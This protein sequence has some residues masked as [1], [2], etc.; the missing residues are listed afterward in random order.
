M[1]ERFTEKARRV[2]FFAHYEASQFSSP[3]IETEH[4]LLGILHE[5]RQL[6]L[7]FLGASLPLESIRREIEAHTTVREKTSTTADLPLSNESKRVLA[8]AAEEAEQLGHGHI[9]TKHFFLGLLREEKSFAAE[10]LLARGVR[11]ATVREQLRSVSPPSETSTPQSRREPDVLA[12]FSRNLNE[13]ALDG[14][15]DPLIGR[16]S[17]LDQILQVLSRRANHNAVLLG[18][19][20]VGKKTIVAG[21]AQRVVDG[22]VPEAFVDHL[23][24]ELNL[25]YLTASERHNVS[26]PRI[27]QILAQAHAIFV[28]DELHAPHPG[29][30]TLLDL[31]KP[32]VVT[33]QIRCISL[34]TPSAYDESL[35]RHPWLQSCFQ[36]ISVQ[37]A[38]EQETL[39]V[40]RGTIDRFGKFH[41]A[42]YSDDALACAVHYASKLVPGHLP[43][44]AISLI[45]EAGA[46]INIKPVPEEIRR[47]QQT[48]R[49][50]VR[51]TREAIVA[52]EF[53]KARFYS[54][55]ERKEREKLQ[56]EVQKYGLNTTDQKT[57]NRAQIEATVARMTGLSLATVQRLGPPTLDTPTS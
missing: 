29:N 49:S 8:Y 53:A 1:F 55:E 47:L 18:P 45:D 17:Q 20:G 21:L 22:T 19:P 15:L 31:L 23:V 36:T 51:R 10:L 39:E 35:Q 57:I 46:R 56:L 9:G 30:T 5:D 12:E 41:G 25:P 11:L 44:K 16:E 4:L 32:L 43:G 38:T 3:Y 48:I 42:T 34:A 37:P 40:L 33:H 28:L 27:Q 50:I 7:R 2:I 14:H 6:T 54:D 52:H 13:A 26:P 24:V